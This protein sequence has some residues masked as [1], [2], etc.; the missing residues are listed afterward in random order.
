M[1]FPLYQPQRNQQR[2]H[3]RLLL[4]QRLMKTDENTYNAMRQNILRVQI[5]A[6]TYLG[7][8]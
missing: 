4:F 5:L 7:R 1:K 6:C 3:L 8:I 2:R